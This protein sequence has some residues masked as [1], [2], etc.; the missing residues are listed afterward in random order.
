M[1][2]AGWQGRRAGSGEG[3]KAVNS[4]HNVVPRTR[5]PSLI[6]IPPLPLSLPHLGRRR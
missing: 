4:R 2:Q 3:G 5:V 6:Y 1:E